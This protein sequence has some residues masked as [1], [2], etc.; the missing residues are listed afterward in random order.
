[1]TAADRTT[2][3]DA[4]RD[5]L[6][7]YALTLDVDD[8]DGCLQLFT[9]D[10]EYLVYG[11]TLTGDRI[12]RMFIR[13]P[14]GM[15]VTGAATIDVDGDTATARSQ[16]LF[17]DSTTR[18]MRGAIYDDDLCRDSHGWHFRRRRCQFLTPAGLR[19]A[20]EED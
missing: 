7:C 10:A 16:V 5:L 8:Y 17:V 19:E 1:M 6:A 9:D 15:H 4:I 14:T 12:R 3:T 11:K 2:D 13:A 18:Q 20:P